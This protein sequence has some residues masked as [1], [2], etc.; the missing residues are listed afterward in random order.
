LCVNEAL[1]SQQYPGQ[2]PLTGSL[3]RI[4]AFIYVYDGM[5]GPG[6]TQ[7]RSRGDIRQYLGEVGFRQM[8]LEL[9][10]ACRV[11]RF[12]A[13][14]LRS[15]RIVMEPISKKPTAEARIEAFA[16]HARA[17]EVFLQ[18]AQKINA[19][20]DA[21]DTD[22]PQVY[23]DAFE[24]SREMTAALEPLATMGRQV[25]ASVPQPSTARHSRPRQPARLAPP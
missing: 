7:T 23:K 1:V 10:R 16:M 5:T 8:L 9:Q 22:A 17:K 21:S 3:T 12:C 25:R 18:I 24:F 6:F 11:H 4:D 2:D 14:N 19:E 13:E 20:I 15:D